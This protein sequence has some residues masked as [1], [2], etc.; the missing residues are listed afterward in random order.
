MPG[1]NVGGVLGVEAYLDR[2]LWPTLALPLVMALIQQ[3]SR[4]YELSSITALVDNLGKVAGGIAAAFALAGI[5]LGISGDFSH[6]WFGGW[7]AASLVVIWLMRAVAASVFSRWLRT[8]AMR[9]QA[10]VF[11]GTLA[12]DAFANR[13][14]PDNQHIEVIGI[15]G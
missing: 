1:L 11:G 2:Y 15:F 10:V 8:G 3:R 12:A 9:R 13:I 14:G 6:I 7:L 5:V 4:L